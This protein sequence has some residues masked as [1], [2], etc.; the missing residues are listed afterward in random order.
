[1]LVGLGSSVRVGVLGNVGL[2]V[3]VAVTGM[4]VGVMVA[5]PISLV[6][7]QAKR[8]W[9]ISCREREQEQ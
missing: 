1:M 9:G 4:G 8:R 7:C 5:T 2:G 6:W 3:G